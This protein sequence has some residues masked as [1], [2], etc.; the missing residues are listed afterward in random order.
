MMDAGQQNI[1]ISA[2][3]LQLASGVYLMQVEA[4]G[5]HEQIRVVHIKN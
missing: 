4:Q 2:T 3:T 5:T 1:G